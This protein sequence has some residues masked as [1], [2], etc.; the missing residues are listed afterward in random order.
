ML[1]AEPSFKEHQEKK[2]VIIKDHHVISLDNQSEVHKP[3]SAII[4][5]F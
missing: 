5:S 4:S 1:I 3:M 2:G